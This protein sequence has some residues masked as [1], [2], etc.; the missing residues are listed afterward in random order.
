MERK[1]AWAC[2]LISTIALFYATDL[3]KIRGIVS[4]NAGSRPARFAAGNN[5]R[6]RSWPRS[7]DSKARFQRYFGNYPAEGRMLMLAPAE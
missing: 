2:S 7:L 4:A 5:A 6:F 3:G 1:S